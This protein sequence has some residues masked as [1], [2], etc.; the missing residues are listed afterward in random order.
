M[1]SG[2]LLVQL[3]AVA[4]S[5]FIW[6]TDYLKNEIE[7]AVKC[8]WEGTGSVISC[9]VRKISGTISLSKKESSKDADSIEIIGLLMES[10]RDSSAEDISKDTIF[11][12]F[13]KI[14]PKKNLNLAPLQEA[15]H[16]AEDTEEN[17]I[18]EIDDVSVS[19]QKIQPADLE[20]YYIDIL[21]TRKMGESK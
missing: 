9:P 7:R 1:L 4:S 5:N 20:D 16:E 2:V 21:L 6:S 18:F 3:G 13:N 17:I 14:F 8:Q 10:P 12:V 15:F 19:V 11:E